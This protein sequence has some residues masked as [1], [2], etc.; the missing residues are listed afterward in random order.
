M[1]WLNEDECL[2]HGVNTMLVVNI[3]SMKIS[4]IVLIVSGISMVIISLSF[5]K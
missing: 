1:V 4:V 2:N 3:A 5:V